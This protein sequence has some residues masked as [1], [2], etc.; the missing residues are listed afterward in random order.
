MNLEKLYSTSKASIAQCDESESFVLN[1]QDERIDFRFCDLYALKKKL[2]AI[3]IMKMFDCDAPDVELFHLPH[4]DRFLVL[5]LKDILEFRE[6]LNGTFDILAL[7]SAIQQ[8]LRLSVF[9]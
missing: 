8:T 9:K 6:L 4:C 5:S 7:N 1:F 3:D 2:M